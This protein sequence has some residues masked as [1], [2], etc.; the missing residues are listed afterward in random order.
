M[1][2]WLEASAAA[3]A[4]RAG[5]SLLLQ[6]CSVECPNK[7]CWFAIMLAAAAAAVGTFPFQG[8]VGEVTRVTTEAANDQG[9]TNSCLNVSSVDSLVAW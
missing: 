1:V 5:N 4:T 8:Y 6:L 2:C 7:L 9:L 3:S